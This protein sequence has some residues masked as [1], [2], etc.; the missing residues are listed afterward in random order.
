MSTKKEGEVFDSL[1]QK[2]PR[3]I[4]TKIKGGIFVSPQVKQ[5]CQDPDFKKKLNAAER[6]A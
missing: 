3:K 4:E 2:F 6:R 5:L 1:G